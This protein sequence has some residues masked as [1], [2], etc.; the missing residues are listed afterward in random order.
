LFD[1]A[2]EQFAADEV[3]LDTTILLILLTVPEAGVNPVKDT[4]P[5]VLGSA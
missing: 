4:V 3:V 5:L 1:T 2:T